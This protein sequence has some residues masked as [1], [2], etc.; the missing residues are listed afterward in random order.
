MRSRFQELSGW[1]LEDS[2]QDIRGWPVKDDTGRE[3]GRVDDMIVDTDSRRVEA[4]TLNNGA[5]LLVSALDIRDHSVHIGTDYAAQ[6]AG[7]GGL[8][9]HTTGRTAAADREGSI[10][11]PIVEEHVEIGKRRV[12]SSGATVRTSVEEK[13]VEKEVTLR[14]EHVSVDRKAANRHATE[15]DLEALERSGNTEVRVVREEPVIRKESRVVEDVV[16]GKD[17]RERKETIHEKERK[18]K[19]NVDT[20]EAASDPGTPDTRR[21]R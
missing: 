20:R 21:G 5:E 3:I 1:K 17:V 19:V 16:I 7:T 14:E 11:I 9:S 15:K 8:M 4:V 2:D 6:F 10:R 12:E 13:P 18:S